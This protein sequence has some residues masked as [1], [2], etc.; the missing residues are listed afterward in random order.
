MTSEHN[1]QPLE[2]RKELQLRI[3]FNEFVKANVMPF[4][5]SFK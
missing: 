5:R 4:Y 3:Q 1:N 2:K